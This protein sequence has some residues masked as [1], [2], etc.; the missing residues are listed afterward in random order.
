[1][2]FKMIPL[3]VHRFFTEPSTK[4]GNLNRIFYP[5]SRVGK[6]S[7]CSR[8]KKQAIYSLGF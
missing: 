6:E 1:M 3:E 4:K 8:D 5:T 2:V 7:K